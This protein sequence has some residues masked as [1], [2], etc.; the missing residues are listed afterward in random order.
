[1]GL[2]GTAEVVRWSGFLLLLLFGGL[3]GTL[4]G[5]GQSL[6]SARRQPTLE[7]LLVRGLVVG[8]LFWVIVRFLLGTLVNNHRL[9][10]AGFL[11][12]F[13]PL[14]LY[15]M[16]LGSIYFQRATSKS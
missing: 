4:F 7:G 1:L 11:Y 9:D 16:L 2:T 10:L 12:S 15:G 8:L 14:L 13:V 5:A 6:L 3:F